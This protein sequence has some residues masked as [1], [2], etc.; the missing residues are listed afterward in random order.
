MLYALSYYSGLRSTVLD[1]LRKTAGEISVERTFIGKR[2]DFLIFRFPGGPEALMDLRSAENAFALSGHF[3]GVPV[4]G[5][6][7]L[8]RLREVISASDF[9]QALHALT[10]CRQ[11]PELSNPDYGITLQVQGHHNFSLDDV[12]DLLRECLGAKSSL[13]SYSSTCEVTVRLQIIRDR[14]F[15]GVQLPQKT[16]RNRPYKLLTRPG[17]LDPTVAF[18]LAHLAAPCAKDTLLDPMCGAGTIPIEAAIAFDLEKI[19]CGDRDREAAQVTQQNARAA[20]VELDIGCWDA[21]HLPFMDGSIDKVV[22]NLPYGKDI[23]LQ[24]P[25]RFVRQLLRELG[26]L[27]R[28]GGRVVLISRHGPLILKHLKGASPFSVM[29]ELPID[30]YGFDASILVLGHSQGT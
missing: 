18:C 21:L 19:L 8:A 7:G 30:L 6:K 1:E 29:K 12:R 26:R 25:D 14:G 3:E 16:M 11:I 13:G 2:H 22:T 23:P 5:N 28:P 27:V 20:R 15:L 17:S 10:R 9:A 24:N 4:S